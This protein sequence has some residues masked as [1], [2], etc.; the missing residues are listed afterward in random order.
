MIESLV[1]A[2][3]I[4][5]DTGPPSAPKWQGLD[6]AV[7]AETKEVSVTSRWAAKMYRNSTEVGGGS[8]GGSAKYGPDSSFLNLP[9]QDML[10]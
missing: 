10:S 5:E 8:K 9:I 2:L 4:I 1:P 7:M 6:K 3:L